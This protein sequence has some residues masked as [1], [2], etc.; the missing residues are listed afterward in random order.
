MKIQFKIKERIIEIVDEIL[1]SENWIS[2]VKTDIGGRKL[3]EIKDS[4]YDSA[5]SAEINFDEI[6]I[7][8]A[9][10]HFHY[11]IYTKNGETWCQYE[12]AYKGLL[13]QRLLPILTPSGNLLDADVY[14]DSFYENSRKKLWE[15]AHENQRFNQ[16]RRQEFLESTKIPAT[17]DYSRQRYNEYIKE[18]YV[19]YPILEEGE[20]KP[21]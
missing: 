18:D 17:S 19:C 9:W 5:A 4:V 1:H 12:G 15:Y 8:T 10:S 2:V 7:R 3:V 14:E 16:L 20:D 13:Q 21:A 11:R 6:L